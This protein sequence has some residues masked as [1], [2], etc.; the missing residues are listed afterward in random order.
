L[1][2]AAQT[3]QGWR[4]VQAAAEAAGVAATFHALLHTFAAAMLRF[5]QREGGPIPNSIPCS[6]A[7]A[8]R[9]ADLATTDGIPARCR[10]RPLGNRGLGDDLYAALL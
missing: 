8:A 2:G 7:G 3:A 4:G 5:L 10:N 6:V 1:S 9:H